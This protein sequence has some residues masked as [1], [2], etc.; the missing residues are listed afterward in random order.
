[1]RSAIRVAL[2][3]GTVWSALTLPVRA[4]TWIVDANNGPGTNF[5][6]IPPAVA[7]AA[8]GDVIVVRHGSYSGFT[9]G[10]G[11]TILGQGGVAIGI[12]G[13][14]ISSVPAGEIA[15]LCNVQ[16]SGSLVSGCAGTVMLQRV[17]GSLSIQSSAD[18][19]IL[20]GGPL[21]SI[22][23]V[24]VVDARVQFAR[25]TF[26]GWDG[27]DASCFP[28]YPAGPGGHGLEASGYSRL[29]IALSAM[30][31]GEGGWGTF[32]IG[33][34]FPGAAGGDAIRTAGPS[35]GQLEL[36]LFGSQLQAGFGGDPS[37]PYGKTLYVGPNVTAW[38]SQNT[39]SPSPPTVA[40]GG[41]LLQQPTTEP[42][43]ELGG[44][45][46]PG[47]TITVRLHAQPGTIAR[48]NAGAVPTVLPTANVLVE[49]LLSSQ[50]SFDLGT[51]PP[52]GWVDFPWR[53][54]IGA[55]RGQILIFQGVLVDPTNGLVQRS[56]SI[57]T[58][59]Q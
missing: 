4:T 43:L 45:P 35:G 55:A 58:I 30:A 8:P 22:G 32:D 21:G 59:V 13:A 48:L 7:A 49:R 17:N 53:Y 34:F 41:T 52:A 10:R 26:R 14:V 51:V 36:L 6:D 56:N 28:P 19:R 16:S 25:S 54:R 42:I 3:V 2:L 11:V 50:F 23:R 20:M 33:C 37:G 44:T 31:G 18:V 5:T 46:A 15:A 39:Y 40:P 24:T 12:G 1:M 47:A 38:T 27:F 57:E 29:H 9:L